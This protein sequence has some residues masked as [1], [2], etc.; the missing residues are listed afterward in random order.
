MLCN[1]RSPHRSKSLE[2]RLWERVD[3]G[4]ETDCWE[5]LG[6][7]HRKGYGIIG[8]GGRSGGMKLTH[9]VAWEI[10]HGEPVPDGLF[11]MHTCD[12]P[13]CCNPNHLE[14]GTHAQNMAHMRE[15]GR[16]SIGERHYMVQHP[17]WIRRG[18]EQSSTKLTED[19]V[20]RIR[21]KYAAKEAT[22]TTLAAEFGVGSSTISLIVNRKRWSHIS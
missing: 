17:E 19:D 22:Q 2:Q 1:N 21:A 20:R 3:K 16:S 15:A 7:K 9:R 12:N 6:P 4:A 14:V 10:T 8:K 18:V 11:V 5:W 13:P